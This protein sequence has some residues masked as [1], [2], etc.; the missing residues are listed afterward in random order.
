MG[1]KIHLIDYKELGGHKQGVY[2]LFYRGDNLWSAGGDGF[3]VKWN[4]HT[5]EGV[6]FAQV[7][8]PIF[9][10]AW[11][12]EDVILAGTQ[13]GN[14]FLL[15]KGKEAVVYKLSSQG[16]FFIEKVGKY[17]WIGLGDGML[18]VL[19]EQL[20]IAKMVQIT[21]NQES[22]RCI[23][24]YGGNA[25]G[26]SELEEF[27]PTVAESV[28]LG[29]S[30]GHIY[31]IEIS[32]LQV[33]QK[34]KANQP[35]VFSM[36]WNP[37]AQEII[38]GGRDAQLHRIHPQ[39]QNRSPQT[40]IPAHWFSIHQVKKHPELPHLLASSS[41]DKSIKFWQLPDL[42]LLKVIDRPKLA[43]AHSH[44]VNTLCWLPSGIPDQVKIASGSDDKR[45][46]I[47]TLRFS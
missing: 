47:W 28:W 4:I 22:L 9:C 12:K 27:T 15:E 46:V 20:E 19:N 1:A 40:K 17:W 25:N 16:L 38:T 45:V 42:K 37:L 5:G 43:Y 8:E 29:A 7:P 14:L 13:K 10:M 39:A 44:S 21:P 3:V 11:V 36:D 30:D 41:M 23:L 24:L 6:L 32:S 18:G 2:S 31:Q 34:I 33:L 35:S 26:F